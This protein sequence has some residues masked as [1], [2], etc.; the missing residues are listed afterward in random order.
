[1]TIKRMSPPDLKAALHDGGEIALLDAR[2]EVAV[3]RRRLLMTACAPLGRLEELIDGMVPRR[4]VRTVWCDDGETDASGL[5]LAEKAARRMAAL[6]YTDVAVLEGGV[7]AWEAAGYRVYAGVHVPSKAFA[8]VV[9]HEAGTPYITAEALKDLIDAKADIAIYDTRSYEEYHANSIPGA[10]SVPGAEIVYRYK[11][12]TPSTDTLIVVNCGGRTRSIIGA[13]ALINAGVPN[14]VVS[15]KNGTQDWHLA[16][17]EVVE[18]ATRRPPEV[19][20]AGKA[21][22]LEGAE[23]VA[24]LSGVRTI[25]RATLKQWQS[26]SDGRT[27]YLIDVRTPEEYVAGHVPGARSVPGGQLVQETDRHMATWGAR[28]VL[29]D[30]DGVRATITASW[31][32]QMG[33]DAVILSNDAAGGATERGPGRPRTLGLEAAKPR[34]VDPKTLAAWK[35]SATVVDLNFSRGYR[36]GHIPG[37]WF[38]LR[39]RLDADLSEAGPIQRLVFTSPDGVLAKLAAADFADAAAETYAL[40]GGTTAWSAAGLPLAK[41]DERMAS[42]PDDIRLRARED[43]NDVEAAM[44]AYLSWEI[45]L[46]NQMA[47][48]DD[49]RFKI[50]VPA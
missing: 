7:T 14:R 46:V 28:V 32:L 4:G 21:A 25:D 34:L 13:Q 19:S 11:D 10:T 48:D 43:P 5:G 36:A 41:G 9:E 2:E 47:E 8:E 44:R 49:H 40:D 6:G 45:E 26:E 18:G 42:L 30:N 1:M 15:L 38:A 33:W 39:S 29:L 24:K 22:A 16:G 17:Y 3:D 27:L 12:L 37:A 50:V 31:L 23:R 35:D 20:P